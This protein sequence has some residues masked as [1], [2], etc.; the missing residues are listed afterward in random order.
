LRQ[1]DGRREMAVSKEKLIEM[2]RKMV[3]T[4]KFEQK[5]DELIKSAKIK[6]MGHFGEGQEA[7]GIGICGPLRDDDYL[8]G[9]HRGFAEY[10]GKGMFI[11]DILL[12][13][14]GRKN[15]LTKGKGGI[16]LCY[17]PKG[18]MGL[19]GSLG[20]DFSMSVGTALSA[21]MRKTDQVTLIYF[22]EGTSNQADFHPAMNMAALWKLPLIFACVNNQYTE[23]DRYQNLTSTEDIA[24]RAGGYG[25]PGVIVKDGNDIVAVYEATEKAVARAR[26]GEGPT[27]IEF[28][29]Y[30]LSSHHTGDPGGYQPKEEIAECRKND[31]V[32]RCRKYLVEKKFLTEKADQEILS[33]IEKEIKEALD[34]LES[35]PLPDKKELYEDLYA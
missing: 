32:P 12:E 7:V 26:K 18:V 13:Y 34:L 17:P 27:L 15:S 14:G 28:K 30:R 29:T 6:T 19:V 4:R 1:F 23:Y 33:E 10:I 2:Y 20:A 3:L 25:M 21:K 22:G 16:H 9:T 24:P 11:K 5:M 8:F 31:P 35:S